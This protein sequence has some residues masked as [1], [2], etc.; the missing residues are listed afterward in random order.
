ML[1]VS[2]S[3]IVL[4]LGL[5]WYWHGPPLTSTARVAVA[6]GD[7]GGLPLAQ[8]RDEHFD[9]DALERVS[10]DRAASGLLAFIVM[11]HG[12]IVFERF[13]HGTSA[14][15]M[16]DSGPFAR[17]LV[18]LLAGVAVQD[19]VLPAAALSGFDPARLRAGIELGAHQHYADYLSQRLWAPLNAGPAWIVLPAA[20][21]VAPA[22]CCFEARILDWMRIAGVL[23]NDGSFED[24]QV[25]GRGWV[26]RMRRPM[27]AGGTEGFGLELASTAPNAR[28]FA[29][30]DIFFLRG[31]GHW[32]LWVMPG[33]HLA[34][35]FG[36]AGETQA[37]SGA[38]AWDETRLPNLVVGALI[39]RPAAR[40]SGSLLQQLVPGH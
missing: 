24:T 40:S 38:A 7:G 34:V 30:N 13:G 14:Q 8:P 31:P 19:G 1:G 39:D 36:A 33:L 11:R 2:A 4:G 37:A 22:D 5:G 25:V 27:S 21:A 10:R 3:V 23:V 26:A 18:G 17:V 29:T 35:L 28:R 16:I 32:R 9:A 15:S 6:G 12:H 20:G